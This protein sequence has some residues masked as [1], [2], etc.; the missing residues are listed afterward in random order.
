MINPSPVRMSMV[1]LALTLLASP[2]SAGGQPDQPRC[3]PIEARLVEALSTTGCKPGHTSCFLGEATGNHG[4]RAHTY[5]KSDTRGEPAPAT[6]S[7]IPYSG[8]FEYSTP[9]GTLIMKEAGL[10]NTSPDLPEKGAVTAFQKVVEATGDLAGS[11]GYFF[12]SGFNRDGRVVTRVFGE[13][14]TP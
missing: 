12:V 8:D 5:F 13:I 2:L 10:S 3:T 7:S 6:P 14:C 1:A 11:T 4:F 9:R